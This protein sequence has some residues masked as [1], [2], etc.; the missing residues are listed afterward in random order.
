VQRQNIQSAL[1]M[2]D[3][4]KFSGERLAS[5]RLMQAQKELRQQ[6]DGL[7]QAMTRARYMYNFDWLGL[8]IIQMPQ[9][10][11]AAQE[12][13]WRV[14]PGAIVETGVARGGSL[15]FSASMLQLLDGDGIVVG[16]DIDIRQHNRE[17]IEQHPLA[18][19]IRL[20]E[21]SSIDPSVCEQAAKHVA[22][23][24][25]VMVFLDSNHTHEHVLAELRLYGALVGRDS[26]IIV[27][28]SVIDRLPDEDSADRPWGPG[29]NPRTAVHAFLAENDRFEIDRD[30]EG[31]L[32]LTCCPDGFLRCRKDP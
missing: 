25:P 31:K 6:A 14:R 21:G 29:N 22:G 28:D 12:L 7:F 24:R 13:I 16:I 15:V 3:I 26:Y 23:R 27:Y 9:D 10:I 19:R 2:S 17:A 20:V 32:L 8:P 18:R 30:V 4:D 5:I 1:I 11:L